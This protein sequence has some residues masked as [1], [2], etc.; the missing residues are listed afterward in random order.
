MCGLC[1]H[2][3]NITVYL[4]CTLYINA[5][6]YRNHKIYYNS[7]NII[8]RSKKSI[9]IE[10]KVVRNMKNSLIKNENRNIKF[11]LSKKL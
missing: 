7:Q 2:I 3:L 6:I 1:A 11:A 5:C 10:L 8:K 9:H 4:Y